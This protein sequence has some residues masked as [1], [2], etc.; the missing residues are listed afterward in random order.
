MNLCNLFCLSIIATA[1]FLLGSCDQHNGAACEAIP[2][3]SPIVGRA[4]GQATLCVS[5]SDARQ[6]GWGISSLLSNA[7]ERPTTATREVLHVR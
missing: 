7:K 3:N 1:V 6:T 2:V 5:P 4:N